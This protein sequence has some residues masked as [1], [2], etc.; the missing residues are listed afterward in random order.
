MKIQRILLFNF[1]RKW[2]LNFLNSFFKF[3]EKQQMKNEYF[4]KVSF[5]P[6]KRESLNS[7][8]YMRL[9][10]FG[11]RFQ[12]RKID[13]KKRRHSLPSRVDLGFP[14]LSPRVSMGGWAVG[15]T[16][17]WQLWWVGLLLYGWLGGRS[18]AHVTTMMGRAVVVVAVGEFYY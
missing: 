10:C 8:N 7:S 1:P 13:A 9:N 16:P 6:N 14:Y 2:K 4:W 17:T 12:I 15:R 3:K 11:V 18:Y 5:R